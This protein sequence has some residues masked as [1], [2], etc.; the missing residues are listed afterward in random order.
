MLVVPELCVVFNYL[1]YIVS[2]LKLWGFLVFEIW[3]KK[4]VMRLNETQVLLERRG[5]QVVSQKFVFFTIGILFLSGKYS[6]LL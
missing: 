6:H 1:N 2:P 5:F 3:T 4:G